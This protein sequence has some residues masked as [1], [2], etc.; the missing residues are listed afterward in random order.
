[1][2]NICSTVF[3]VVSHWLIDFPFNACAKQQFS[4]LKTILSGHLPFI[5]SSQFICCFVYTA[6]LLNTPQWWSL[7]EQ[8]I[9]LVRGSVLMLSWNHFSSQVCCVYERNNVR[10]QH[11]LVG[12][13]PA[14]WMVVSYWLVSYVVVRIYWLMMCTTNTSA[15]VGVNSCSNVILLCSR[16]TVRPTFIDH[17]TVEFMDISTKN[18]P[19]CNSLC[20]LY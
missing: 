6:T 3:H 16:S 13:L 12:S 2:Y 14:E 8:I 1:M 20:L 7:T 4:V 11:S 17:G 19:T 5:F 10:S 15:W 9:L 18:G